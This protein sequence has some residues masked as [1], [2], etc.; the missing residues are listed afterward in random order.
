[1]RGISTNVGVVRCRTTGPARLGR[2]LRLTALTLAGAALCALLAVA[3]ASAAYTA[4]SPIAALPTVSSVAVDQANHQLYVA[5][6]GTNFPVAAGALKRFDS[7]GAELSCA[8]AP[9]H[10]ASVAVNPENQHVYVLDEETTSGHLRTYGAEC[11]A[12]IGS[13]FAVASGLGNLSPQIATDPTGDLYIPLANS[14]QRKVIKLEPS[15]TEITLAHPIA[16]LA[17]PSAAA[18]DST[19]NIYVADPPNAGANEKQTV[20][21]TGLTSEASKFTLTF[22]GQTTG[23]VVYSST[24]TTIRSRIQTALESLSTV[25]S[26]NVAVAT[27]GATA[28]VVEFKGSL[29]ASDVPLMTCAITVTP[30]SCSAATTTPPLPS[31]SGVLL[32]FA[33]DGSVLGTLLSNGV[34]SVAVDKLTGEI[35]AGI[36]KG[37]SFH[38][39]K[40]GSGGAKLADFGAGQFGAI[41]G[42]FI[43]N[44]LAVDES[45]GTVYATDGGHSQVLPFKVETKPKLLLKAVKIGSGGGTVTS[46]RGEPTAI[47]CGSGSSCEAEFEEGSFVTL[48][49]AAVAGSGFVK[50]ENCTEAGPVAS[51][52][53]G[54][55]QCRVS[56]TAAKTVQA[57]FASLGKKLK[58]LKN[59][60]GTGTVT[61]AQSGVNSLP[62]DCG[63]H[64]EE[65]FAEN[66]AVTLTATA[67][68]HKEFT[69]WGAGDC[70]TESGPGNDE[71]HVTLSTEKE[72]HATFTAIT[73]TLTVIP[74]GS[75]TVTSTPAGIS[76]GATCSAPFNEESTVLLTAVPAAHNKVEWGAGE[77]L[78]N[79]TAN[80]CV[81]EVEATDKTVHATFTPKEFKLTVTKSGGGSGTV[82]STP[83]GISC[84]SGSGCE[85]EYEEG[86]SVTLSQVAAGGSTFKEWTG[87]CSGS[88]SCVVA[89]TAAKSVG[90][91]F[92]QD[93]T[94]TIAMAGL[95]AGSVN[96]NGG[97]CV[98][99]Y[100]EGTVVTLSATA[101]PGSTFAGFSGA[102]CSSASTCALTL[103]ADTAVTATFNLNPSET[104]TCATDPSLCPPSTAGSAKVAPSAAVS[105]GTAALSISCSGG[106]ACKGT[107]KLTAKIKQGGKTKTVVI[108]TASYDIAAGQSQTIKVKLSG[109]AK[110]LLK[111]GKAI[112]AKLSGPGAKG[113]VKLKPARKKK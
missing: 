5:S 17:D 29:A 104:K 69:G 35:F 21:L 96:C 109:A 50:W 20:S 108:G 30:G 81:V 57:E 62:I 64:C 90:A 77:C 98:P 100:R 74:S 6:T 19:G 106:G 28:P 78:S 43:Y 103:E 46:D 3:D 36:G 67:D 14:A 83:A 87:A 9:T 61:S 52:G 79:P 63:V 110:K 44:Q 11:G 32:K 49:A 41:T 40:Y 80:E 86:V 89:M 101:A 97:P 13:A 51:T 42:S 47:N 34:T 60:T 25:G 70:E 54:A 1:M 73:H 113:T 75:G 53:L 59:G 84:G 26:G 8:L 68:P 37:T 82:T 33:P 76:C 111:E 107:L 56:M 71:C 27:G 7:S 48:T 2:A 66:T 105:G 23:E 39:E 18:L 58:V 95:G 38:I 10:P 93:H 45:S 94:L 112:K 55:N 99:S 88:G 91:K 22:N 15:G 4:G 31:S 24:A 65:T 102:G 85:H 92:T 16:N 72:V 12:E